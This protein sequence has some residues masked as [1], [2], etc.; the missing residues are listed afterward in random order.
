MI[1]VC[2]VRALTR[3][4]AAVLAL[5]FAPGFR[6]TPLH[7]QT[8]TNEALRNASYLFPTSSDWWVTLHDGE[9]SEIDE[10]GGTIR[11]WL[12]D[13]VRGDL[14][15]DGIDEAVG[16]LVWNGGGSGT[17]LSLVVV[18]N[19]NGLPM[20][21]S[22]LGIGDRIEVLSL[23]IHGQ[24]IVARLLEPPRP[25]PSSFTDPEQTHRYEWTGEGLVEIEEQAKVEDGT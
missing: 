12:E 9:Y 1:H 6:A 5:V 4:T 13:T 15:G 7:S 22:T 16:V 21:R 3:L 10:H 25:T 23:E 18:E 2:G 20:H 17:F 24:Q 19:W 11:I 14:D 8:L